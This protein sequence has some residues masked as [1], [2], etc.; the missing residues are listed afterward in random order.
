LCA[1]RNRDF[2]SKDEA[3]VIPI[4]PGKEGVS[5]KVKVH[6]R[7]KKSAITGEF[8]D[9]LKL[10]LTSPPV[11]GKANAECIGFFAALFKVPRSSVTIAAGE[12][13]RNKVIRV[14]GVSKDAAERRLASAL[15]GH[16]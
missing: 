7:T 9:T 6:P 5:F 10:A 3:S 14:T 13:S 8:G 11:D 4:R 12:S 2:R 15:P 16:R 1:D